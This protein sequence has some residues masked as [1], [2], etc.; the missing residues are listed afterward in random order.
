M[1][2][3]KQHYIYMNTPLSSGKNNNQNPQKTGDSHIKSYLIKG[4]CGLSGL[5]L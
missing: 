1:I 3:C 5:F 2:P 4:F